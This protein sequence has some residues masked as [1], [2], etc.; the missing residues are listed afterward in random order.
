MADLSD[1]IIIRDI[2][3]MPPDEELQTYHLAVGQGTIFT[4]RKRKSLSVKIVYVIR[5]YDPE[6]RARIRDKIAAWVA[7]GGTLK[8]S[9]RRNRYLQVVS[10]DSPA[11]DS[12]LKWTQDL[13]LTLTAYAEP[14]WQSTTRIDVSA[15]LH[16][17][18][19]VYYFNTVAKPV[20][21]AGKVPVTFTLQNDSADND[22]TDLEVRCGE[23]YIKLTGIAVKPGMPVILSYGNDGILQIIDLGASALGGDASLLRYRTAESSDELLMQTGMENQLQ[24]RADVP[25]SG[26]IVIRERWL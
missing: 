11:L 7:N 13:T 21:N 19:G 14:Y 24:I 10:D 2:V 25:V 26:S 16:D 17:E 8:T 1:K 5:E 20:S 15:D 9:S 18:N 23:T 3:E 4:G 22:L 6:E 12:S